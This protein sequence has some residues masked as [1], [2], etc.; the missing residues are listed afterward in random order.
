MVLFSQISFFLYILKHDRKFLFLEFVTYIW[1]TAQ[2]FCTSIN[3]CAGRWY[4]GQVKATV[5]LS[6][7]AYVRVHAVTCVQ[8]WYLTLLE[9]RGGHRSKKKFAFFLFKQTFNL[10]FPWTAVALITTTK[11]LTMIRSKNEVKS[12]EMIKQQNLNKYL[13]K[14]IRTIIKVFCIYSMIF[15]SIWSN[16]CKIL[17]F[18][19]TGKQHWR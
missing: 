19:S 2:N 13:Y 7:C 9:I 15:S 16:F 14:H 5:L 18:E 17:L 4:R 12:L 1:M 6:V 8:G 3:M 11:P 10:A